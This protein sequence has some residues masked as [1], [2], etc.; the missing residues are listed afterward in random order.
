LNIQVPGI[1]HRIEPVIYPRIN[2]SYLIDI[3]M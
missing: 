1:Y 2:S 3:A